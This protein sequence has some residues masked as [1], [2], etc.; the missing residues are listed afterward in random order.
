MD[1]LDTNFILFAYDYLEFID[2]FGFDL[3]RTLFD[4]EI[5][6]ALIADIVRNPF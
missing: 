4:D 3:K 5:T 1:I 2:A 6:A